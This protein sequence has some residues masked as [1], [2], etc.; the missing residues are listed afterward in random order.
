MASP[1]LP[2]GVS[3]TMIGSMFCD[4]LRQ[5]KVMMD[6]ESE[7]ESGAAERERAAKPGSVERGIVKPRSETWRWR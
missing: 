2:A 6:G 4:P 5:L 7:I 3:R 1:L